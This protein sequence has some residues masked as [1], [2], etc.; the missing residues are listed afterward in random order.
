[1]FITKWKESSSKVTFNQLNQ[2]YILDYVT[3]VTSA[4]HSPAHIA[5]NK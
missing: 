2:D 3:T 1:M 4:N 5:L